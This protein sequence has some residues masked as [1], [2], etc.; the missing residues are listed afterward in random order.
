MIG[1]VDSSLV[2][3]RSTHMTKKENDFERTLSDT[4]ARHLKKMSA[5]LVLLW[6]TAIALSLLW[7]WRHVQKTAMNIAQEEAGATY[8]RDLVYRMWNA[9]HGGVYV[10]VTPETPPNPHLTDTKERDIQTPSGRQLTLMNPAYMTRQVHELGREEY[11]YRGHITSLNPIRPENAPDP[12]E[13]QALASFEQGAQEAV[14]LEQ[15][16][17]GQYLRLMRPMFTQEACLKCHG[18]QGYQVG[19]VRGGISVSVPT[20]A[21]QAHAKDNFAAALLFHLL[22]GGLGLAGMILFIRF[23]FK[24]HRREH[25][26][27]LAVQEA[28]HKLAEIMKASSELSII[29]T[30]PNGTIILF[31]SGAEKMLGHTAAEMVGKHTPL[32]L[33]LEQEVA[34]RANELSKA[35]G[36]SIQGFETFVAEAK[37]NGSEQREWTYVRR[38][39]TH[40]IVNLSITAMVDEHGEISG[41]L[42]MGLDISEHRRTQDA[43]RENEERYR[44]LFEHS[45]DASFIMSASEEHGMRVIDF[46]HRALTLFGCTDSQQV[47]GKLPED[48]SPAVQPDGV[49]S[50]AKIKQLMKAALAGEAQVFEWEHCRQN[51]TPFMVEVILSRI[52]ITGRHHLQ[53]VIRDITER[54][55]KEKEL[56]KTMAQ[57]ER[58]NRLMAGREERVIE[59]K[60]EVNALLRELERAPRYG[61]ASKDAA[62]DYD[63]VGARA[64]DDD[65]KTQ[66]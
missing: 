32:V 61:T 7:N 36:R 35:L 8:E 5:M 15:F 58:M 4:G 40:L 63:T 65:R 29:A 52:D 30:D 60:N 10:P 55:D 56:A 23:L 11:G 33:H 64:P 2:V 47:L 28:H 51:G 19:D 50:C 20:T 34:A 49:P 66:A 9:Q 24:H 46:N 27:K 18:A 25:Q 54:K 31:N 14:T 1:V 6:V 41:F 12:W 21:Y 45:G 37:R 57:M 17:D 48:F 26:I 44:H 53:A 39:G 38:D 13:K 62:A 42:G 3:G 43:L 16:A 22:F 59:M